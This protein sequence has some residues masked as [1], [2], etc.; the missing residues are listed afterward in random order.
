MHD[1]NART[2]LDM[3]LAAA[4]EFVSHIAI[5]LT[6]SGWAV[7]SRVPAEADPGRQ[8]ALLKASKN[9]GR[10]TIALHS[11]GQILTVA[12]RVRQVDEQEVDE[13]GAPKTREDEEWHVVMSPT[14]PPS[15][16]LANANL[17]AHDPDDLRV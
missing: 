14:V 5:G 4:R 9:S 1:L 6:A 15:V 3:T 8:I 7:H 13:S 10:V 11:E 12:R 16:V 17:V 2:R